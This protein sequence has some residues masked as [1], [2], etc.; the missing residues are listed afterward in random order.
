MLRGGESYCSILSGSMVNDPPVKQWVYDENDKP[1]CTSFVEVGSKKRQQKKSEKT[2]NIFLTILILVA[3]LALT[4]CAAPHYRY[5]A[6]KQQWVNVA[7]STDAYKGYAP[8][9]FY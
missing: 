4:S 3:M 7:D 8:N 2:L 1:I 5:N 6:H 9:K